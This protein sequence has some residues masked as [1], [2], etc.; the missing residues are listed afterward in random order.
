MTARHPAPAPRRRL[1][2]IGWGRVGRA[3]VRALHDAPDLVLAGIVRRA[4]SLGAS[5]DRPPQGIPCVAHV[6]ELEAVDAA[7]LCVPGTVAL[8][9]ARDLLQER[10]P[11]VECA[12]LEGEAL[13]TYRAELAHLAHRHRA[14]VVIGAGWD[15]GVLD[16]LRALFERL[17]PRGHT[18]CT[19]QVGT[20]LHHTA[21]AQGVAGVRGALCCERSGSGGRQ[22]YVYVELAPGADLA[23][24]Q[25]RIEADP[26]FADAS[27]QVLVVDDLA[28]LERHNRGVLIERLGEDGGAPHASLILEAR[29]DPADFTARLMLDAARALP[30]GHRETWRH[31]PFGLLPWA[32]LP[33][34]GT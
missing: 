18:R 9:I 25:R 26:L 2:V 12:S 20:S 28:A 5:D 7:L 34:A 33:S 29:C 32:G 3:C 30:L 13:A 1:A 17:I 4:Q 31:T 10:L 16:D 23:Q 11:L 24:V 15:P 22:R 21:A 6:R 27:T 19:P 14:S 8:D